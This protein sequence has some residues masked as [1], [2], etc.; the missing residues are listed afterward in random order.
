MVRGMTSD[1]E[2]DEGRRLVAEVRA[3]AARHCTTC[4]ALVSDQFHVDLVHERA[5]EAAY[6]EMAEAKRRL[7][8]HF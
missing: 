8:D 2:M 6:V 3:A 7:R 5:E 4:V 1:S